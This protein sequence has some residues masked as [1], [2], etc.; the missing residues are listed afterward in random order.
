[1]NTTLSLKLSSAVLVLTTALLS[2]S[3]SNAQASNPTAESA[4]AAAPASSASS[5][6]PSSGLYIK[7][8]EAKVKKSLMAIPPFQFT[9]SPN[10]S[11]EGVKVGKDIFDT[12]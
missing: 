6:E 4:P 10:S 9:G 12:F 2:P 8:D 5:S 7:I 1:M 3:S 11:K